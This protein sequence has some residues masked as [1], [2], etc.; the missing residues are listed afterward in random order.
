M[1]NHHFWWENPYMAFFNSYVS[2]PEGRGYPEMKKC[3]KMQAAKPKSVEIRLNDLP[4]ISK[5]NP[6]LAPEN[7]AI[8]GNFLIQ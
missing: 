7:G 8:L 4:R 1:E 6:A 5:V 3:I 2:L